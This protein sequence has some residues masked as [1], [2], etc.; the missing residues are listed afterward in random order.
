M[1]KARV[2]VALSFALFLVPSDQAQKRITALEAKD[3]INESATV[4][5]RAVST[6]FSA[7]TKGQPTFLNLEKPYPNQ[8]FTVVIWGSDR[9]KFGTPE[10]EYKGKRICVTGKIENFR[11]VPE[12]VASDP[13]QIKAE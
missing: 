3:H 11:G 4:C 10:A 7:S 13:Q 6:R 5:G 1:S 9:A 12:I 8:I 2:I